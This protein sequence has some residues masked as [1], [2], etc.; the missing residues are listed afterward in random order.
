M[1]KIL[2]PDTADRTADAVVIGGGIV[3]VATAYFLSKSGLDTVLVEARDGLGTLTT[4]ASAECFRAQFTEPAIVPLALES[5]DFFEHFADRVG[6]PGHEIHLRKRGY[7]FITDDAGML[8]QLEA[9]IAEQH[10]LGVPDS[11]FLTG[12][13]TRKRFPFLSPDVQGA[14]FRQNDGWL[15][16]HELTQGFAKASDA[17][18]Y[19]RTEVTDILTDG[20]GGAVSGVVTDRGTISTRT[21]VDAAGPFAGVISKMVGVDLPL[22]PVL[23]Q[24]VFVTSD[25]IP[26]D[27]PFTVNLVNGSYW[28]PEPGGALVG[29]VNPDEPASPPM[30]NPTGDWD[31]PAM[32]LDK[33]RR[34]SPFWDEIIENLKKNDLSVSAGQYVYTPDQQPIIGPTE[35]PGFHVNCGY[36]IGVMV[37]PGV[38]R[39]CADLVT[40]KKDNADNPLRPSRFAEG[41]TA[42]GGSFLS[43]H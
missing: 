25:E 10:R 41:E 16:V 43:G 23:R 33:V 4:G 22:E 32:A 12:E 13:E 34:L 20:G 42:A 24:K 15:S 6:L 5:P 31:F 26:P 17:R 19:V 29:W 8:P 40:G 18:F 30:A 2:V 36:W 35:V 14:T 3:G 7:L 11:E 37:S 28:R 1:R 21:V 27:A 39:L 38:G 9:A